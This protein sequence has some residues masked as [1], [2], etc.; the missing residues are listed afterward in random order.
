MEEEIAKG[1][2]ETVA[3]VGRDA[4]NGLSGYVKS[5][6]GMNF[7]VLDAALRDVRDNVCALEF[8]PEEYGYL[9]GRA[10][11]ESGAKKRGM[12]PYMKTV[13][14]IVCCTAFCKVSATL[15]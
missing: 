4:Y 5:F 12:F 13:S 6:K 1:G 10:I 2:I 3:I 14:I 7:I 11:A 8:Q 9:G 15:R